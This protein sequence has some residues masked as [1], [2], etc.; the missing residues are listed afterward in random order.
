MREALSFF[1]IFRRHVN[2]LLFANDSESE[3]LSGTPWG[4]QSEGTCA[5]V[6]NGSI[7]RRHTP[8]SAILQNMITADFGTYHLKTNSSKPDVRVR[9]AGSCQKGRVTGTNVCYRVAGTHV[10]YRVTGTNV[11][12]RVAIIDQS[13]DENHERILTLDP[14]NVGEH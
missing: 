4:D 13:I 7:L 2:S 6:R 10:C 9:H 1:C 8:C 12:Y 14:S 5:L 3:T 11:C